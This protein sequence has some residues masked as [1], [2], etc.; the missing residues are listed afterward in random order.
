MKNIYQKYKYIKTGYSIVLLLL[1]AIPAKI[2]AEELRKLV[3]LSGYWKFS[4]GDY[5]EWANPGFDDSKWDEIR[6]PGKWEDS[7]YDE[8]NG[9][10]WYRTK[11]K[12]VETESKGMIYLL[13]GRIDDVNEVYLNG[14]LLG[15]SGDFPPK[16]RTAYN[17]KENIWC[18]ANTLILMGIIQLPSGFMTAF[19]KVE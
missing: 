8:Y 17:E 15:K 7:G 13:L 14:K 16:Y 9:Y 19:W 6:V 1:L 3:Q 4:I 12:M 5:Q 18:H 11:F 2:H 10:A